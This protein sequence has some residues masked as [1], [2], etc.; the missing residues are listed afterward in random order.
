MNE[1]GWEKKG[2]TCELFRDKL[3][4]QG[5]NVDS[6]ETNF[7]P[8]QQAMLSSEEVLWCVTTSWNKGI[9]AI[10]RGAQKQGLG[11]ATLS[12][13]FVEHIQDGDLR[14]SYRDR[15]LD[16]YERVAKM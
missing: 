8:F 4:T 15:L 2:R 11:L 9:D 16:Q 10:S 7:H 12:L 13:R 14:L 1:R 5:R 3:D 6:F